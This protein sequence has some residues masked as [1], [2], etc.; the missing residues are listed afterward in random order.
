MCFPIWSF[1]SCGS[2]RKMDLKSIEIPASKTITTEM[3]DSTKRIAKIVFDSAKYHFGNLKKGTFLY[4]EIYYTNLGPGDLKIDLI[5]ACECTQ[6][7]W[8][9]L[10]LKQ[11]FRSSLKIKYDSK[12]K[13]GPQIVDIEV[14]ANTNPETSYC[15]FYLTVD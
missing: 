12:D 8:S 4:K 9:R 2:S 5:S 13:T 11:G 6:I 1:V 10:P 14:T 7:D 3:S 15:K